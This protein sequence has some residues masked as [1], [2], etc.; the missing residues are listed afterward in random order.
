MSKPKS[1]FIPGMI[2][3]V[4][5]IGITAIYFLQMPGQQPNLS[6]QSNLQNIVLL[7]LIKG[8]AET[9]KGMATRAEGIEKNP[10]IEVNGNEVLYSRAISH[11]CCRQAE[12]EKETQNST[13]NIYEVWS[14]EGCRCMCF[15][16]IEA[17]IQNVPSGRYAVNVYVKG[18]ETN[19]EPIEQMIIISK[20]VV[21]K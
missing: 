18:T 1:V 11:Q 3:V 20:D 17:K 16:E 14:G 2:F 4:I 21:I 9:D 6:N 5:I 10:Q 15:S 19:G 8:C 7:P 12:I 13:I